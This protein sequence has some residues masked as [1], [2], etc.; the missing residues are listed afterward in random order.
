MMRPSIGLHKADP[1]FQRGLFVEVR[2]F[3]AQTARSRCQHPQNCTPRSHADACGC[4]A[5][6]S[7]HTTHIFAHPSESPPTA[8]EAQWAV[9]SS[10][11][12]AESNRFSEAA[13][14]Q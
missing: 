13:S 14:R 7:R 2:V 11:A 4:R 6:F 10:V 5:L 9:V 1:R 3:P 12:L 8:P